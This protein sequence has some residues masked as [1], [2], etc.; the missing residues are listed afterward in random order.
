MTEMLNSTALTNAATEA[1][2]IISAVQEDAGF[3][4]ILKFK[5]GDYL[6][7]DDDVPLGT[8]FLHT[9]QRGRRPGSNSWTGRSLIASCI[10]WRVAKGHPN[11]KSWTTSTWS[12]KRRQR[13]I[14]RSLGL[15]IS[16]AARKR[17][18]R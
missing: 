7:D 4:K 1:D 15:S 13:K 5:K 14:K 17:V 18:E 10:A 3:G 6:I 16:V 8:K 11:A 2:N 9:P 12:D